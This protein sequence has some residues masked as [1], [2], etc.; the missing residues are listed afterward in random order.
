MYKEVIAS[1]EQNLEK[2]IKSTLQKMN[3]SDLYK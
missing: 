3:N 1:K 2:T